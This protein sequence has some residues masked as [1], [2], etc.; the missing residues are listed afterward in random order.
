METNDLGLRAA[1]RPRALAG[2]G[3]AAVG[4]AA[5]LIGANLVQPAATTLAWSAAP[6]P[7]SATQQAAAKTA[8]ESGLATLGEPKG[9]GAGTIVNGQGPATAVGGGAP[10][11]GA[12]E[13]PADIPAPTLPTEL[14][15]L[16]SL[17]LHGTGG[18]AVFTD[19]TTTA[20][21]LLIAHGDGFRM[22]GLLIPTLNGSTMGIAGVGAGT[23]PG[24]ALGSVSVSALSDLRVTAM[25]MSVDGTSLGIIAGSAP[26]GVATIR[27]MGGPADGAT[28]T[29]TNGV[30]ALWAPSTLGSASVDVIALDAS[31]A[32]VAR[33]TLFGAPPPGAEVVTSSATV[34]STP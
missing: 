26:K 9:P 33:Q 24:Q 29:V 17:E 7:V 2:V 11:S 27:V 8:C 3:L 18:I 21:C 14:P 6:T 32:E 15:P 1:V 4:L 30:F 5:V 16:V 28:A 12:I 20:Y 34:Q 19:D 31:G 22:G 10:P 25:A 13:V 23:G